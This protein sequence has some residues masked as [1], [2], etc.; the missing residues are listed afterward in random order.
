MGAKVRSFPPVSGHLESVD[1]LP[2]EVHSRVVELFVSAPAPAP[3]FKKVSAPEP[4][5]TSA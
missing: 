4:A 5:P 3:N 2:A 1:S